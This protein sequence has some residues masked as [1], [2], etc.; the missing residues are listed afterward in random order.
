LRINKINR[1]LTKKAPALLHK[2]PE[3][4]TKAGVTPQQH[5]LYHKARSQSNGDGLF[6]EP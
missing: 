5:R 2:E 3:A 6:F 4:M 1:I